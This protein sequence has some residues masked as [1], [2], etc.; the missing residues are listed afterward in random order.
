[1]AFGDGEGNNAPLAIDAEMQLFA[2]LALLV[3]VLLSA[4]FALTA[5]L[6]ASTI[7]GQVGITGLA[8]RPLDKLNRMRP[9]LIPCLPPS[10]IAVTMPPKLTDSRVDEA[11]S[12]GLGDG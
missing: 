1:M 12:G 11:W 2:A 6:N 8:R 5:D 9:C 7:D 4:P 3:A 10:P